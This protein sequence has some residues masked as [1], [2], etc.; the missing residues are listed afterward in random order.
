MADGEKIS[1][2]IDNLIDNILK[3]TRQKNKAYISVYKTE[4][5]VVAKFE[6][7]CISYEL[8][9]AVYY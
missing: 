6:N 4:N 9:S 5:T 7:I 8:Q 1:S 2:V 3:F